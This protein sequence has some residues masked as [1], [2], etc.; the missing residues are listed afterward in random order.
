MAQI[1][2]APTWVA[3]QALAGQAIDRDYTVFDAYLDGLGLVFYESSDARPSKVT[4]PLRAPR[5]DVGNNPFEQLPDFGDYFAQGSFAGGAGQTYFHRPEREETR[6]Y[7]SEGFDIQ[8]DGSLIHLHPLA[9]VPAGDT[10]ITAPSFLEIFDD[11][12]FTSTGDDAYFSTTGLGAWTAT[13]PGAGT[14]TIV[15]GTTNGQY[16]YAAAGTDGVHRLD[17]AGAW[18]LSWATGTARL[19]EWAKDRLIVCGDN[20]IHEVVAA[21][22]IPAAFDTLPTGWTFTSVFESGAFIFATAVNAASGQSRIYAYGTASGGTNLER[23]TSTAM[24]RGEKATSGI[25]YLGRTFIGGGRVNSNGGFNPVFYQAEVDATGNL[26]LDKVAG[27]DADTGTED[28]SVRAFES[29]GDRIVF[30]WSL[31]ATNPRGRRVGLAAYNLARNAFYHHVAMSSPG[32]DVK[33]VGIKYFR[34]KLLVAIENT[35]VYAEDLTKF[36]VSAYL[37]T[38]IADWNNAGYKVWDRF[39][40]SHTSLPTGGSID[41]DYSNFHPDEQQWVDVSEN[42]TPGSSGSKTTDFDVKLRRLALKITSNSSSDQTDAATI[43]GFTVRSAQAPDIT[44]WVL[45]RYVLIADEVMKQPGGEVRYLDPDLILA[46]LESTA[47]T[48]VQWEEANG[49]WNAFVQEVRELRPVLPEYEDASGESA[50]N[51]HVVELTMIGSKT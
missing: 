14:Q 27:V 48:R 19:V 44:E 40:I 17:T 6:Y 5:T 15:D 29:L 30:G 51:V 45:K 28:L 16:L 34:G 25:G 18:N 50:K 10:T 36:V 43:T 38:S 13:D 35:G 11:V 32:A 42:T 23:K 3:L 39:E 26:S 33:V 21:G 20:T 41:I 49:G 31:D 46:Q 37:E 12:P 24:P 4:S 8:K 7:L 2:A 22:A 1:L 47:Y 9:K